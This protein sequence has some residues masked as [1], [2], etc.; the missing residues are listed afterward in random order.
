MIQSS[1]NTAPL[2]QSDRELVE[3]LLADRHLS[4]TEINVAIAE[5]LRAGGHLHQHLI[6]LGLIEACVLRD[7]RA[8]LLQIPSIDLTVQAP[9]PSVVHLISGALAARYQILP[10]TQ[11]ST[12]H[13]LLAVQDPSDLVA[14]DQITAHLRGQGITQIKLGLASGSELFREIDRLFGE[15]VTVDSLLAD[16]ATEPPIDKIVEAVLQH[17]YDA[18]ASDV[19]CEPNEFFLR[20][21]MRIDGILRQTHLLPASLWAAMAV[22]IK[23]LAGMNIA[24]NR[25]AQDGRFSMKFG[26][27]HIDFRAACLP[28]AHGENIVIRLLDRNKNIVPFES[29]DISAHARQAI[30]HAIARPEGIVLV[31][32]PTGSGKTTTLYSLL[33]KI[34]SEG[35]NVMT[36]EDPIEYAL[37]LIRQTQVNEKVSFANGIRALMRQDPDVILVGEIRDQET[38]EM[39]FRAAMT[40]HQVF[41]TLHT[42]SAL[43][44]LQRLQDLGISAHILAGNLIAAIGQRLVRKLCNFCKLAAHPSLTEQALLGINPAEAAQSVI[45]RAVGCSHCLD[46]GYRGRFVLLEVLALN[47]QMDALVASNASA[48]QLLEQA[49]QA[50][51]APLRQ[52]AIDRVLIGETTVEEVSRVVSLAPR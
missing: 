21:R 37:P 5:Q 32:G 35:I 22:R 12:G 6:G 4:A 48:P 9:D 34:S 3:R 40:G 29:M 46:T 49:K 8:A 14:V 38:A 24:E 39:A 25:A 28:T 20:I 19:H 13:L 44:S 17:S 7:V 15:R 16:R 42:N 43:S 30:E 2:R 33:S 23:V 26:M 31:T 18:Q 45:Y 11:L 27:S 50:G 1:I 52:E 10:I 47:E 51:F 41:A 36:L